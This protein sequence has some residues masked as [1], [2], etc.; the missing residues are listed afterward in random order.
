MKY[1]LPRVIYGNLGDLASRW[2]VLRALHQ[3]GVQDVTVFRHQEGDLPPLPFRSLDYRPFHNLRL[4]RPARDALRASDIVLWA[5]GLDMQDD[6]SIARMLYLWTAFSYYRALGLKIICLFQGAGPIT[7]GMGRMLGR[8]VLSQV[9]TFIARDPGTSALIK[10]LRPGTKCILAHDAIFLPGFEDDLAALSPAEKDSLQR[11]F[12]DDDR[13]VIGVNLRQWFHFASSLLPY[14]FSRQKY[15]QRSGERM[16]ELIDSLS[17]LIASLRERQAARTLLIS[18]YQPGVRPWE[19]DLPWLERVKAKFHQDAEVM[20]VDAPL[21][22][23]A[24]FS[25]MSR[26]HLMIGMRL[27]SSLVAL[28]FGVPSINLSYTLKGGDILRHM[29]LPNSVADLG[30]FIDSPRAV[31]EQAEGMLREPEAERGRVR[32]AV[33]KAV[34][35]NLAALKKVLELE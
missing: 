13:P 19:D 3:L 24:Y 16:G 35:V 15:M 6:S 26:L 25:L 8:A 4:D 20:L 11:F 28:R 10:R 9:D 23:P 17:S 14:Q 21:G 32:A 22:M 30:A 18:A 33:E 29:G 12:P 2:G 31:L 7:T 5:V 34:Q 27:H 1:I